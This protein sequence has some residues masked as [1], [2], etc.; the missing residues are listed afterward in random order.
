MKNER[1]SLYIGVAL[2]MAGIIVSGFVS[3]F[4]LKNTVENSKNV[5][6]Q[7]VEEQI[8]EIYEIEEKAINEMPVSTTV[9]VEEEQV[10]EEPFLFIPPVSGEVLTPFSGE[11]LVFSETLNDY[12]THGGVDIKSRH[13]EKVMAAEKGVVKETSFDRLLGITIIIDHENGFETVYSNLSTE[14]MVKAGERIEKGMI[15]SGVGDT[16]ISESGEEPHLH[17][18]IYKDGKAVNPEEYIA[19]KKSED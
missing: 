13:L 12:R 9:E 5:E 18:E 1:K 11:K 8:S 15:I 4:V 10:K 6:E 2:F 17:F 7:V 19:F 16:A 3:G 14:N